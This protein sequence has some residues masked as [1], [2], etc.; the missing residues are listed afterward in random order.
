[1]VKNLS[2]AEVLKNFSEPSITD[3]HRTL[4]MLCIK[5]D[6]TRVLIVDRHKKPVRM[7][8]KRDLHGNVVKTESCYPGHIHDKYCDWHLRGA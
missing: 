4:R 7:P 1:M 8:I 2:V 3:L 5:C 6:H